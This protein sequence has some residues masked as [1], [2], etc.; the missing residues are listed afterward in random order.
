[1]G[2]ELRSKPHSSPARN[3]GVYAVQHVYEIKTGPSLTER[4]R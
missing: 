4:Y 1:M 2:D 3:T